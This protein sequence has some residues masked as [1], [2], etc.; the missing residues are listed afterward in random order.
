MF[1]GAIRQ[2]VARHAFGGPVLGGVQGPETLMETGGIQRPAQ[3][4]RHDPGGI[5][6]RGEQ[7]LQALGSLDASST[8]SQT[9]ST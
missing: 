7:F 4:G 1:P 2:V 5:R 3:A 9:S 6:A 8:L